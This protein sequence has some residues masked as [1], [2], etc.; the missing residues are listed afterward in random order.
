MEKSQKIVDIINKIVQTVAIVIAGVWALWTWS[1][2][3]APG[4]QTGLNVNGNIGEFSWRDSWNA[5]VGSVNVR[6]ENIGERNIVV[7]HVDYKIFEATPT[8]L[9]A[10]EKIKVPVNA[11]EPRYILAEGRLAF[12]NG[13][14]PPKVT[15]DWNVP[16]LLSRDIT[17][18]LWFKVEAFD[19]ADKSLEFWYDTIQPCGV[20]Q[21]EPQPSP[22]PEARTSPTGF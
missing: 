14:Y 8:R 21:R 2:T 22:A 19:R 5:C 4:L 6:L 3:T 18:Q 12:L 11:A 15:R 17:K 9:E 10:G 13:S 16:V 1:K 7:A 20:E